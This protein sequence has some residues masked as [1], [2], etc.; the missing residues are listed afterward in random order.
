MS[1]IAILG[2][3]LLCAALIGCGGVSDASA[4]GTGGAGGAGGG[5]P[6]PRALAVRTNSG[7]VS[8]LERDGV[9]SYRGIPY[10]APPVGE[11][12]WQAPTD[13]PDWTETLAATERPNG[14]IQAPFN[15]LPIPGFVAS[16]DCLYLNVDTPTAGFGL[17]VMVWI[18]GGGFTLGEAVQADGGTAGDLIARQTGVVVVSMNYRLGQLGFLAHP[19]LSAE[20]ENGASGN[21][22]LMDQTAALRWVRD[23][24]AAFGG[25][26]DNVTIFGE[27]A[28]AF[29]VC[30][31]VV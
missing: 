2:E 19:E 10:A 30:S 4:G 25:D 27:S 28:G 22:G 21:Y 6:E 18:H 11:L 5:S 17:P 23:N 24:I 12:R 26:L 31:H 3:V 9:Y 14:C 13:P 1:R 16:E 29:S 7:P 8:G 15:G 20:G